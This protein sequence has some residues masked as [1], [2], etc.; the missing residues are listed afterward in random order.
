MSSLNTFTYIHLILLM[1]ERSQFQ[2]KI[3]LGS[4]LAAL[5][6]MQPYSVQAA[7]D[8]Y[9]LKTCMAE[10]GRYHLCDPRCSIKDVRRKDT[11][12]VVKTPRPVFGDLLL[13]KTKVARAHYEQD[14]FCLR[15][16]LKDTK[17][18]SSCTKQCRKLIRGAQ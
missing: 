18:Y 2:Y 11:G 15:Q 6:S 5:L 17:Q 8:Y 1:Y 7:T 12:L 9:C 13:Q 16:C 4:A 14:Y 10:T 3:W